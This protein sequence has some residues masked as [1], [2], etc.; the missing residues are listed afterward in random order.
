MIGKLG[1]I[2]NIIGATIRNTANPTRL[3]AGYKDN[4]IPEPGV[5]HHRLPHAARPGRALPGSS[6]AR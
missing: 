1:P 5:G 4:V 6:C 3:A 2:A